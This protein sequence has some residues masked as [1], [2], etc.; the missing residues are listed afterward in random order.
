MIA[1]L[2]EALVDLLPA[3]RPGLYRA[4][5]GGSPANVALGLG[6]LGI[7]TSFFG[8]ISRDAW[9]DWIRARLREAGV[10]TAGPF[11][12]LPTPLARVEPGGAEA[13]YA[14]YLCGTAFEAGDWPD[15]RREVRAVHTG[16][17]ATALEPAAGEVRAWLERRP[18]AFFSF[19]PNV[20]PGITPPSFRNRFWEL[21]GRVNLLKLSAADLDWLVPDTPRAKALNRL[22]ERVGWLVLTLGAAGAVGF[23]GDRIRT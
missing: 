16:S 22:R 5:P 21:L 11:T 20:R 12:E 18:Q 9:G 2:G 13:A 14:F 3:G 23:S 6:R 1:V 10:E 7:P 15:P 4:R 8:G 17:L 19:D